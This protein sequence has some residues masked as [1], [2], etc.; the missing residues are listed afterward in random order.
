MVRKRTKHLQSR[1]NI[2]RLVLKHIH[3]DMFPKEKKCFYLKVYKITL[4]LFSLQVRCHCSLLVSISQLE[5]WCVFNKGT[6]CSHSQQS[7]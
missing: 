5:G 6:P 2:K 3:Q 1:L 7:L 4:E